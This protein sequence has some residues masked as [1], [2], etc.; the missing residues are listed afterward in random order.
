[1]AAPGQRTVGHLGPATPLPGLEP[2][3]SPSSCLLF[4]AYGTSGGEGSDLQSVQS[5]VNGVQYLVGIV[6]RAST[7]NDTF[8]GGTSPLPHM[9][10]TLI[11]VLQWA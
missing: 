7:R 8:V 10:S 2:D 3:P 6:A 5:R 11:D 4:R 9:L 1:M